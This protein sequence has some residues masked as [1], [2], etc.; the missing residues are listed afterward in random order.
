M[1][2][3][4]QMACALLFIG[5]KDKQVQETEPV[6]QFAVLTVGTSDV[7]TEEQYPATIT[8]RQ[9]V[10]I[11]PQVEGK[12]IEIRVTEGQ[13]VRK[14]QAL[15]IIDQVSYKAALQTAIAN[16][17]AAKA[18]LATAELDYD[19]T[20]A[21]ATNN[22]VS[23]RELQRTKNTLAA[24]RAA[25]QQME[26]QV[27]DARNN[28][29][30]T[31]VKSPTDGVV[32]TLP[33]RVGAL[34]SASLAT[35][36]TTISDNREVYVYFSLPENRMLSLIKQ[37]GAA[38]KAVKAMP[39][40]SLTLGDGS[41]YEKQGRVESISGVLDKQTGSVSLRAVFPNAGGLLHSGGAGSVSLEEQRKGALVIPQSAT[42]EIQD[43]VFAY[44]V[45]QGKAI[46]TPIQVVAVKAKQYEVVSGL[47]KGD[48]LV[49]EGVTMV[50]D[51]MKIQVKK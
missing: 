49:A 25:V 48:L 23:Q 5:C 44:R 51:G 20:K 34:V 26:A 38:D 22:V 11:Y 1:M 43:K 35:P 31:V 50:Q 30:Y 16:L 13:S 8:G 42:F 29:S 2:G 3:A 18:Q 33:Y 28:L 21:L 24:A 46:A 47:S 41:R 36:L 10:E 4:W 14:G 37:Y 6:Q 32:G 7:L 17:N 12:L 40:V 9:D 39:S 27:T 15:F 19:G 45:I